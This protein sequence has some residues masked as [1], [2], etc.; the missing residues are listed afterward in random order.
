MKK[1]DFILGTRCRVMVL[2]FVTL[3]CT[4]PKVAAQSILQHA[5]ASNGHI[6]I[7]MVSPVGMRTNGWFVFHFG[8]PPVA[9][10]TQV[11]NWA[12]SRRD[13][14]RNNLDE[15]ELQHLGNNPWNLQFRWY[16][17]V[18]N[19][20]GEILDSGFLYNNN[21]II[22][23]NADHFLTMSDR[24]LITSFVHH[25]TIGEYVTILTLEDSRSDRRELTQ[26]WVNT[27]RRDAVAGNLARSW[28]DRGRTILVRDRNTGFI[29]DIGFF[30]NTHDSNMSDVIALIIWLE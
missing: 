19:I 20:S 27:Q 25:R 30:N 10:R 12:N 21:Q 1:L 16:F 23:D 24:S 28:T 29:T 11:Q 26:R 15:W 4:V 14:H 9:T 3:A 5:D 13:F 18:K 8:G 6:T 7:E 22:W 2:L 17:T